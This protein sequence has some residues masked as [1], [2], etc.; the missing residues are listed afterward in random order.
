[1]SQNLTECSCV[2]ILNNILNAMEFF[3]LMCLCRSL[4]A[5]ACVHTLVLL[6][7]REAFPLY[8]VTHM[9]CV[10]CFC[11]SQSTQ[12]NRIYRMLSQTPKGYRYHRT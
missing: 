9:G 1:M 12:K 5:P 8:E 3:A 2:N 6:C 7:E 10:G 11:L 4:F